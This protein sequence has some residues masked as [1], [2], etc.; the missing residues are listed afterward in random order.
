VSSRRARREFVVR[1]EAE[2]D[3]A[4]AAKWYEEESTGLGVEFVRAVDAC[5]SGIRRWP[6]AHRIE[7]PK[8][9]PPVRRALVRRFP[10]GVY[11]LVNDVGI[12]ILACLHQRHRP[13]SIHIRVSD[14]ARED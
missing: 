1:P 4:A 14:R 3:I 7:F 8:L 10:F 5:L 9:A 12:R 6:E 13:G 2:R 11:Y